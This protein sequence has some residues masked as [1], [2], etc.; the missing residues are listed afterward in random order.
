MKEQK[1]LFLKILELNIK[2]N[3]NSSNNNICVSI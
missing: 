2:D 3:N 1:K